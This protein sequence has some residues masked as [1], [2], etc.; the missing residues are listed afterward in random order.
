[1]SG[2][3]EGVRGLLFDVEGTITP[4]AFVKEV[5]FPW[6]RQHIPQLLASGD[7]AALAARRALEQEWADDRTAGRPETFGDGMS[8][9]HHLM[10][11]DSKS[12]ALKELQG[13]VWQRGYDDGSL[14][15]PT[16][17]D[18]APAFIRFHRSHACTGRK[19]AIH[20]NKSI[21]CL[22]ISTVVMM[23]NNGRT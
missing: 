7:P 9:I 15:A 12:T 11:R 13:L 23:M 8:Y 22:P 1:M 18:V 21:S 3:L 6:A 19:L 4:I 2:L 20:L 17:P 14:V 16:F 5:L 10:D